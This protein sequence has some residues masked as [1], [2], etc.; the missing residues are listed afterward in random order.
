L[1]AK[2]ALALRNDA[3]VPE[4]AA[5]YQLYLNL[6]YA[7]KNQLLDGAAGVFSG[8]I[9]KEASREAEASSTPRLAS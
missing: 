1:E 3:M 2:V 8:G 7:R 5:K 9:G 4:L 6:I